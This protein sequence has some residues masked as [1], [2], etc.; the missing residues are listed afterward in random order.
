MNIA[1][2]A[3]QAIEQ[4]DQNRWATTSVEK[5]LNLLFQVREN[6][7]RYAQELAASD[8]KMKNQ[9]LG[10]TLY[11]AEES[12]M[13]TVVPMASAISACIDLYESIQSGKML[14]GISEHK[15]DGEYVDVKVFPQQ[16]KDK[17]MY[18]D[19]QDFIR[20]KG[21]P[22][23]I[24]PMEKPAQTIAVLG[25]GNY[26]SALEIIKAVFLENA[27]V[28]HKPHHI[29][30]NTDKVW[31]K[32]FQ[33]LNNE[34]AVSFVQADQGQALTQ[35]ERLTRIFF[36][37]GAATAQAIMSFT[38]TELVSECGGNNPCIIVPGDKPWTQKELEHQALQIVSISK[39]NGG[40]VC[41]R[42]Q[43]IVTCKNWAQRE[44]FIDALRQAIVT[45]TPAVGTYYPGSEQVSAGFKDKHPNA[46]ILKPE[47]GKYQSADFVFIPDVA[48]D[49]YAVQN[50]AF[51]QVLNELA[52]DTAANAKDFLLEAVKFSNEKA[53]G[54]LCCAIIIDEAGKKKYKASLEQAVNELQYGAVSINTMP[55]FV[56]LNPYLTWG[57]NEEGQELV[58][59]RGHFGNLLCYENIEKSIV[60]ADFMS[61]GHMLYTNKAVMAG[62]AK[63]MSRYA[64]EPSWMN[65][66]K[67][68]TTMLLGKCKSK[69]F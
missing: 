8:A 34:K 20:I 63:G 30:S 65:I 5:R 67:M 21:T 49:S 48:Q 2:T 61:P 28:I 43:T 17:I 23:Q 35:D 18:A 55:P 24:N 42:P 12:Q 59:G 51:C 46:E 7:K 10:E 68:T 69:D 36:T 64:A 40:A 52:L 56:F 15:V 16:T 58:S 1:E 60:Y 29:N 44:A 13:N 26:S 38:D 19:R 66:T 45:D 57:G 41:G 11:N 22:K 9:L 53:L 31:A 33:P 62:L 14:K 50:E 27:V 4:L 37:G 47:S 3:A 54:T 32:V 6:I 25:A 39:M